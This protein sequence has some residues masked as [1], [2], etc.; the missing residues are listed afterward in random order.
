[1]Q[2]QEQAA[3]R[4]ALGSWLDS[5]LLNKQA[6]ARA[7]EAFVRSRAASFCKIALA[8]LREYRLGHLLRKGDSCRCVAMVCGAR[9]RAADARAIRLALGE[10]GPAREQR[11][12][13]CV[14]M[15]MCFNVSLSLQDDLRAMCAYACL[16]TWTCQVY[17]AVIWELRRRNQDGQ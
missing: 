8:W 15:Y 10:S 12:K 14:L 6:R 5:A 17:S 4:A 2:K 11:R 13:V 3:K 1:M 16:W 7:H 9:A